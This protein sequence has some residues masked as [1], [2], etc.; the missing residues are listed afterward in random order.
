VK[1]NQKISK[2]FGGS[3]EIFK[4]LLFSPENIKR[5]LPELRDRIGGRRS[6][7]WRPGIAAVE[8]LSVNVTV[9]EEA[10]F[11]GLLQTRTGQVERGR[12]RHLQSNVF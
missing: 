2:S 8:R 12:R 1:L 7:E 9:E 5:H 4:K 10:Q 6:R 3:F 11:D